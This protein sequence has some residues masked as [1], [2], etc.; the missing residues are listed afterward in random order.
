MATAT[1][2]RPRYRR[3]GHHLELFETFK[4]W[5]A[6]PAIQEAI[7]EASEEPAEEECTSNRH[8][9]HR[10]RQMDYLPKVR[11]SIEKGPT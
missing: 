4:R 8:R 3:W 11:A 6:N 7:Q 1:A 10:V 2:T 5:G 9:Y